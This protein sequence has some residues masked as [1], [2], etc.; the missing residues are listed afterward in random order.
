[1]AHALVLGFRIA[2]PPSEWEAVAAAL[3]PTLAEV[4]G[5]RWK[6]WLLDRERTEVVGVHLF[7]DEIAADRYLDSPLVVELRDAPWVSRVRVSRYEVLALPSA[8]T[9]GVASLPDRLPTWC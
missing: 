2:I 6:L 4:P 1:M 5:L 8:M 7:E 3:A 9:R